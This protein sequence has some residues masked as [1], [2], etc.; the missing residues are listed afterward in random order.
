MAS[1]LNPALAYAAGALTILSPCVLPLVPIVLSSAAQRH[2]FA[3][4]ALAAGL[5]VA[6]TATGF[7]VANAIVGALYKHPER[8]GLVSAL[9][10]A[11]QYGTGILGSACVGYFANGTPFPMG[12]TIAVFSVGSLVFS[13]GLKSDGDA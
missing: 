13:L 5:V 7:I 11:L 8:A 4:L 1:A 9:I 6:F 2:R 3:P 10:G 12:L